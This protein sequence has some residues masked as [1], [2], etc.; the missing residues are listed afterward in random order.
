VRLGKRFENALPEGSMRPA[1]PPGAEPPRMWLVTRVETRT[2]RTVWLSDDPNVLQ[3]A[4]GGIYLA[5]LS[6]D[7]SVVIPPP[8]ELV[9]AVDG[10]NP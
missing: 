10:A 4:D 5:P 9:A 2:T 8:V 3:E 7:V 6:D 1:L